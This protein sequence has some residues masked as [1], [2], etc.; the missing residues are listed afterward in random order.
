[1][2]CEERVD[3]RDVPMERCH[4]RVDLGRHHG[5]DTR[6]DIVDGREGVDVARWDDMPLPRRESMAVLAVED[7]ELACGDV[8]RLVTAVMDVPRRLITRI[9]DEVPLPDHE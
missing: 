6:A 7:V 3:V 2:G 4:Q 5:D 8:E 9:R 1:M